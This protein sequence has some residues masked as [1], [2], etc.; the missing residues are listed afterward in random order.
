MCPLYITPGQHWCVFECTDS[1]G[2]H[3]LT[4]NAFYNSNVKKKNSIFVEFDMSGKVQGDFGK[5]EKSKP[6][7][8]TV[9][10]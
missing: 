8:F 1:A 10:N 4:H 6:D 5:D 3:F 9:S 2:T 7:G